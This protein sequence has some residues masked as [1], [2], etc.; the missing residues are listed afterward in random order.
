MG[1]R[2]WACG[3]LK[4]RCVDSI[5]SPMLAADATTSVSGAGDRHVARHAFLQ[6]E[7]GRLDHR[8]GV[9]APAHRPVA[10]ASAMATTL[11]P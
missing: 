8:L 9:E 2:E 10:S 4:R 3:E 5:G 6:Q 7:F 1:A 11:M